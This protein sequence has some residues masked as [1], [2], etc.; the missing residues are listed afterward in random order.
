VVWQLTALAGEPVASDSTAPSRG[1]HVVTGELVADFER[2]EGDTL[3]LT[4][5]LDV[6]GPDLS[7]CCLC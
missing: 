7:R 5:V 6:C 4:L 3:R 2:P 1:E